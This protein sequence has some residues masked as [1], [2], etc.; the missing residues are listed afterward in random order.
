MKNVRTAL[1]ENGKI[2]IDYCNP[3]IRFLENHKEYNFCYKFPYEDKR[4]V[5]V[6]EKN[7]YNQNTQINS[8]YRKYVFPDGKEF[9]QEI[10]FRIYF[11][12]EL[13]AY[14]FSIEGKS[15]DYQFGKYSDYC[16]KQIMVLSINKEV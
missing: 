12:Q 4:F 5:P 8:E 6:Y 14:G 15:G 10:P 16:V 1:N 2:I 3:D 13:D 9:C 11:P 7:Y